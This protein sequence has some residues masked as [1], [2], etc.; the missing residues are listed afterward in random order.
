MLDPRAPA[1]TADEQSSC[2][3]RTK[4]R[5]WQLVFRNA[6]KR[7][8]FAFC[9]TSANVHGHF[10][11]R[12]LPVSGFPSGP[13]TCLRPSASMLRKQESS[14]DCSLGPGPEPRLSEAVGGCCS[15]GSDCLWPGL[16]VSPWALPLGITKALAC[17]GLAV[18]GQNRVGT[19]SLPA[20]RSA[21]TQDMNLSKRQAPHLENGTTGPKS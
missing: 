2:L 1:G 14:C 16:P 10:R 15:R 9:L 3:L 13:P 5:R 17:S 20:V 6:R 11:V 19:P 7:F 12:F 8:S 21:A 18:S 4:R